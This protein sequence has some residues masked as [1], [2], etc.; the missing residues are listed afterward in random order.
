MTDVQQTLVRRTISFSLGTLSCSFCLVQRLQE[1][2]CSDVGRKHGV[3]MER[4]F[5]TCPVSTIS[6][7]EERYQTDCIKLKYSE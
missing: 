4:T 7:R 1:M 5:W 6:Q 3:R 2:L